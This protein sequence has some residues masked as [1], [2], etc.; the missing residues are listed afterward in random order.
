[1]SPGGWHSSFRST[2]LYVS[3]KQKVLFVTG[4]LTNNYR[5]LLA[6]GKV[7]EVAG[8]ILSVITITK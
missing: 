3:N 2:F 8:S 4:M 5:S 7:K 1:M 6:A